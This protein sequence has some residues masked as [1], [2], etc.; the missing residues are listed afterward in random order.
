MGDVIQRGFERPV[1]HSASINSRSNGDKFP[2]VE[3]GEL[4]GWERCKVE[5]NRPVKR[6]GHRPPGGDD[7]RRAHEVDY[8]AVAIL[9]GDDES[10]LT[11]AARADYA[12]ECDRTGQCG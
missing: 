4:G 12:G 7:R 2:P 9:S 11:D 3:I 6:R 1:P 10:L 8:A 5:M